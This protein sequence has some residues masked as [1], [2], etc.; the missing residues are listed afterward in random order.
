MSSVLEA[1]ADRIG[2]G[3]KRIDTVL[4]TPCM[5][6]LSEPESE[7]FEEYYGS[8]SGSESESGSGSNSEARSA[9]S[10]D[11][12]YEDADEYEDDGDFEEVVLESG[13]IEAAHILETIADEEPDASSTRPQKTK[14][15]QTREKRK[16]SSSKRAEDDD[17]FD[18]K[19][20]TMAPHNFETDMFYQL[21]QEAHEEVNDC[22]HK[23]RSA[24]VRIK[25]II[26]IYKNN[27]IRPLRRCINCSKIN[28]TKAMCGP[29][30]DGPCDHC[31]RNGYV[32]L[33]PGL[34]A[35]VFNS[36]RGR[37]DMAKAARARSG[38]SSSG[39]G[40]SK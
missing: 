37:T 16:S 2:I 15:T 8:S 12:D 21:L 27:P 13:T 34:D 26:S 25:R 22:M 14:K 31:R 23:A 6:H 20:G 18:G 11:D 17:V 36:A 3:A 4:G 28:K 29:S 19:E 5:R 24:G 10:D 32:C 9:S 38:A 1:V 33:G 35:R 7:A 40:I 30:R 39:G